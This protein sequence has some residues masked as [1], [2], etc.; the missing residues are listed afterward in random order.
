MASTG[1]L[2]NQVQGD[3]F[4][5]PRGTMANTLSGSHCVEDVEQ[6]L[7]IDQGATEGISELPRLALLYAMHVVHLLT[8]HLVG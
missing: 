8:R 5:R 2:S 4:L 7:P 1:A 3:Y 6:S